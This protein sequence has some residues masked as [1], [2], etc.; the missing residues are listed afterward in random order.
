MDATRAT[1]NAIGM[2]LKKGGMKKRTDLTIAK[3]KQSKTMV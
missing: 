1:Y 3:A 2:N